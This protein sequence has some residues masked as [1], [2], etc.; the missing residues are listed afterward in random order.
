MTEPRH[1]TRLQ[2]YVKEPFPALSHLCGAALA[3]IGLII[4][5]E[6]S[7]QSYRMLAASLI[8]GGSLLSLFIAS[9]LCHGLHCSRTAAALFERLDHAAIFCL[10]AGTYTPI[11]LLVIR[12]PVGWSMLAIEWGL[13]G[14]GIYSSLHVREVRRSLQVITYLAMGWLFLFALGP[15]VNA[16]SNSF[17]AWLLGGGILYSVGSIFFLTNRPALVFGR[18]TAHDIWHMFVLAGSTCH[19]IFVNN[20]LDLLLTGR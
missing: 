8:Y 5:L 6:K 15:I 19:F 18:F 4:L 10:I 12:G 2:R 17:L 13:A 14:I 9:S 7:T 1:G 16:I 11:C 3:L 20:Y